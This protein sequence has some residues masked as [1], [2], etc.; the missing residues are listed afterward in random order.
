MKKSDKAKSSKT[1]CIYPWIHQYVGPNGAV[2]PCCLYNPNKE[3]IGSLKENSLKEIWNNEATKQMRLDML[4]GV[5]IKGCDKCNSRE[6]ISTVH[7]DEANVNWFYPS[8]DIINQMNDDGSMPDHQ[9]KYIDARFN[10]LC[11]F[12]CRTCGPEFSTSWYEDYQTMRQAGYMG[13]ENE[14]PKTLIF[15]GQNKDQLLNEILEQLPYVKRIYFA[16]G[17]PL[18]QVEHYIMLEKLIELK[19]SGIITAVPIIVYSTNFSTLKLGNRSI[20]DLWKHFD[21][22]VL[23]LSIDGSYERAEYWRKGTDWKI[24]INNLK[25]V[26]KQIPKAR[27]DINYTL[28]W[29]NAFNLTDL[30]KEWIIENYINPNKINVNCLD[31]PSF[32][33]LKFIPTWKKKKIEQNFLDH[34]EWLKNNRPNKYIKIYD[35]T[36]RQFTDAISFMNSHDSGD[37]F[38]RKDEFNAVNGI[39][40]QIRKENFLNVFSEHIDMIEFIK[41]R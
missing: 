22:L 30:H 40:D 21:T 23:N 37:E 32:Y 5:T 20:I 7:R 19:E 31:D 3:G 33:S 6:G 34:I 2:K 17:E 26:K 1:F 9:L 4:N 27:I 41:E 35:R 13:R 12:K 15:P 36:I 29:V 24:T 25:E 10:N 38:L 14:Y 8:I 11:N 16:G 39:Y 18:M 28:S